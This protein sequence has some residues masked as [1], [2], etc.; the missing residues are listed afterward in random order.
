MGARQ[1][2]M[3]G[4]KKNANKHEGREEDDA[5]RPPQGPREVGSATVADL[6]LFF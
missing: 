3:R 6:S 4:E 5:A 1:E 2:E